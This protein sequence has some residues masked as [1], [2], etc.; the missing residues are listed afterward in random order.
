VGWAFP[1]QSGEKQRWDSKHPGDGQEAVAWGIQE[2]EVDTDYLGEEPG[3]TRT[4]LALEEVVGDLSEG[5]E[6]WESRWRDARWTDSFEKLALNRRR[7]G[8][9]PVL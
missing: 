2:W 1:G 5:L 7:G 8:L 4:K 6:V 9:V 3:Q